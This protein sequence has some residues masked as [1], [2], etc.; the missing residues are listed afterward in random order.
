M[1]WQRLFVYRRWSVRPRRWTRCLPAVVRGDDS[2]KD[3]VH[4]VQICVTSVHVHCTCRSEKSENVLRVTREPE[5]CPSGC[6]GAART[7]TTSADEFYRRLGLVRHIAARPV[8]NS[9]NGPCRARALPSCRENNNARRK[10][11][12]SSRFQGAVVRCAQATRTSHETVGQK[13]YR[14]PFLT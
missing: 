2:R 8:E 5:K 6:A 12:Y 9:P 14:A 7:Q 1:R 11:E 4:R 10:Y 3:I 13:N